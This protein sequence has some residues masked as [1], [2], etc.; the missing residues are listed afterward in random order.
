MPKIATWSQMSGEGHSV[1]DLNKES[2]YAFYGQ[3]LAA[4]SLPKLL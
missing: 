1:K 2:F 3:A 4:L